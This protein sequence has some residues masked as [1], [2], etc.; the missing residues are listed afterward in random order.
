MLNSHILYDFF[1]EY[2]YLCVVKISVIDLGTNTFHLLIAEYVDGKLEVRHKERIAVRI[3]KGGLN[4]GWITLDAQQRALETMV[5]F[6]RLSDDY[7]V[8]RIFATGT[9]AIRNAANGLDLIKM[10]HDLTS[11][12][13][14]I[15][16]GQ[17]EAT[18]IFE[19]AKRAVDLANGCHLIIDIGGGSIEFI[20]SKKGESL[21]ME[22]FEIGGQRLMDNFHKNDPVTFA[23]IEELEHYL[24]ETLQPLHKACETFV[25]N[26]LV[27]CSGTFDTLSDIYCRKTNQSN[28]GLT[29]LPVTLEFYHQLHSDLITMTRDQRSKIPGMIELRVDMIVVASVLISYLIRRYDLNDMKASAYALKEGVLFNI[30]DNLGQNKKVDF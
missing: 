10:I 12:D 14:K 7:Q 9:S 27:G 24:E 21:W 30:L 1:K 26:T 16:S 15:I 25:P 22:S 23:E 3:G 11:I 8:D 28:E 19:G 13:V 20:I 6:K 29:D 17:E 18:L 5:N 2:V 4:D